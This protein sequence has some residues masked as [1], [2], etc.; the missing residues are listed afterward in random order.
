MSEV[1]QIANPLSWLCHSCPIARR[2]GEC[3]AVHPKYHSKVPLKYLIVGEAPGQ[4]EEV[5]GQPFIGK[6]GQKLRAVLKAAGIS[7]DDCLFTNSCWCGPRSEAGSTKIDNPTPEE[8]TYCIPHAARLI[9]KYRPQL[10]LAAGGVAANA[11]CG[12][13]KK[14]ITKLRGEIHRLGFSLDTRY[15]IFHLWQTENNEAFEKGDI[16]PLPFWPAGH[17]AERKAQLQEAATSLGYK[18]DWL[19]TPVMPVL[20]PSYVIRSG[21]GGKQEEMLKFDLIK[22][23]GL[24]DQV[25]PSTKTNTNYRWIT[26]L[27]EWAAY[28]DETLAMRQ[29]GALDHVALD[30]ETSEDTKDHGEIGLMAFDPETVVW[31]IQISRASGEAVCVMANHRESNFNDGPSFQQFR[32]HL[33][34]LVSIEQPGHLPIIGQNVTFDTNVLRCFYGIRC[35]VV[36]DTMLMGHFLHMGKG[37]SQGLDHLGAR[38]LGT[39]ML[40]KSTADEWRKNNP[41]MTFEDMPLEI[42]LDYAAGDADVTFRVYDVIRVKLEE[43]GRWR[44]YYD[45]HHGLHKGWNVVNDMEWAGMPVE[46]AELDKLSEAYPKRIAA[47]EPHLNGL[48]PIRNFNWIRLLEK[49]I[50]RRAFNEAAEKGRAEI[51][52]LKEKQR[53]EGSPVTKK[54]GSQPKDLYREDSEGLRDWMEDRERWYNPKSAQQTVKMWR[55]VWKIPFDLAECD[56]LEWNDEC[57][58]CHRAPCK[59]RKGTKFS[60]QV[61]KANEHNRN[62]LIASL[63]IWAG[64]LRNPTDGS[65]P[66]EEGAQFWLDCVDAIQTIDKYKGLVKM[67]GTYVGSPGGDKGIYPLIVD[68]PLSTDIWE[69]SLRTSPLYSGYSDLPRPWSTHPSYL[70]HGTNT[71]RLS[72][73][74][75]NGQ[76]Y[77]KRKMD[78]EANVK[79]PYI[80]HWAGQG[81]LIVQPDYSQIEVRIMVM[82]CQDEDIAAQINAGRDIHKVTAAMVFG[83]PYDEVTKV[84][85]GPCK[86][87]TF[88]ILYGQTVGALAV[89][90]RI[91]VKEAEALVKRFFA[92]LPKVKAFVDGMHATVKKQGYVESLLGRRRYIPEVFEK[93]RGRSNAGLRMSVNTPIQ[94]TASDLCWTAFGRSWQHVQQLGLG[95]LPYSI[96]H[97]SQGLDTRPG[98]W[99]DVVELMYYHMVYEPYQLW[100]WITVKPEADFEIGAGWGRLVGM[101]LFFDE[102]E[103]IDHNRVQFEGPIADIDAVCEEIR[104][105]GQEYNVLEDHE[106]DKEEGQWVRQ[107]SVGRAN[108]RCWLQGRQLIEAS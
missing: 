26:T 102:S 81:G 35:E 25:D 104:N 99:Y 37:L 31:T 93:D 22:A 86:N 60:H 89:A 33:E 30:L 21:A 85:R 69:P 52:A 68:K 13:Q 9:A 54:R 61:P 14:G 57:P 100:D 64:R 101:K 16:A 17:D 71:G 10:V 103:Q 43:E 59:C 95:S 6:A 36:G 91:P 75:P 45:I 70:M 87:V 72:S 84:Q 5:K 73:M 11:L 27:E 96:I 80:S 97:D 24:V 28:V 82:M 55:D 29:S 34:R 39:G 90:L 51:K 50:E 3:R 53:A 67:F 56:D 107:I 47:L 78:P 83:V 46:K 20:H 88:G 62:V 108:P 74:R 7:L 23:R 8:A 66:N 40:H 44:D 106:H 76:N 38:F 92:G 58:K 63:E 12:K 98:S 15:L 2:L 1:A 4:T 41:G 94:S 32:H 65:P 48:A 42:A 19:Q 79:R 77:P 18:E 49:N 105:G